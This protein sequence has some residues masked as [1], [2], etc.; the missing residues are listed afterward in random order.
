MSQ[1]GDGKQDLLAA[2]A[3][4]RSACGQPG[5]TTEE[6]AIVDDLEHN[7]HRWSRREWPPE[8]S[9]WLVTVYRDLATALV[10]SPGDARKLGLLVSSSE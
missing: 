8:L 6:Q 1:S 4:L 7:L 2:F 10:H 5:V 9:A 3:E